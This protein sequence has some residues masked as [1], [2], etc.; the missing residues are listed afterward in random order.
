MSGYQKKK[1]PYNKKDQHETIKEERGNRDAL[2]TTTT[3]S[4]NEFIE[5]S[6]YDGVAKS[7]VSTTTYDDSYISGGCSTAVSSSYYD[8]CHGANSNQQE[9]YRYRNNNNNNDDGDES[10]FITPQDIYI[11]E[12]NR[13]NNSIK[14]NKCNNNNNKKAIDF[15]NGNFGYSIDWNQAFQRLLLL[16]EDDLEKKYV[17][18]KHLSSLSKD[19]LHTAI[20]YGKIIIEEA[21]IDEK[22]KT[23]KSVNDIGGVAGGKKLCYNG[24]LF[25]FA[26]DRFKIYGSDEFSMKSGGHELKSVMRYYGCDG[27]HVPLMALL[28][29]RGFRLVAMSILPITKDTIIYGSQDA[30]VTVHDSRPEF[31]EYM[32][33]AAAKLNIKGHIAGITNESKAFLYGPTDIEGH[34]G[35]DGLFYLLDFARVFPPTIDKRVDE[36]FLYRLFRP[37]FLQTYHIPLSSDAASPFSKSDLPSMES[38]MR[39]VKDATDYLINICIPKL[40]EWMQTRTTTIDW[41]SQLTEIIHREGV[42]IRYLGYIR[43]YITEPQLKRILL[44]EIVARVLKNIMREELREKMKLLKSLEADSYIQVVMDFFNIV[45]GEPKKLHERLWLSILKNEILL[46]FDNSLSIE[47][48]EENFDIRNSIDIYYV[49]VRIQ[50]MTGIKLAEVSMRELKKDYKTFRVVLPDIIS[51]DVRVKHMNIISLAEGNALSLQCMKGDGRGSERLFKLA[52]NKFEEA[53]RSTPDNKDILNEYAGVLKEMALTVGRDDAITYLEKSY[54]NFLLANNHQSLLQLGEH[55]NTLLEANHQ[56]L[57]ELR[58]P[59]TKVVEKC[60]TSVAFWGSETRNH[61]LHSS[62]DIINRRMQSLPTISSLEK[63]IAQLKLAALIMRCAKENQSIELLE[64]SGKFYKDAFKLILGDSALWSQLPI[65]EPI[66]SK[67][68]IQIALWA[69]LFLGDSAKTQF[70][71]LLSSPYGINFSKVFGRNLL[72]S[73]FLI[74]LSKIYNRQ[75][76]HFSLAKSLINFECSLSPVLKNLG[77]TLS[78]LDLSNCTQLYDKDMQSIYSH[79]TRLKSINISKTGVETQGIINLLLNCKNLVRLKA[80]RCRIENS[81]FVSAIS[82]RQFK[83]IKCIDFSATGI[84]MIG[85]IANAM[86]SLCHVNFS[87]CVSIHNQDFTYFAQNSAG[88]L[89]KANFSSCYGFTDDALVS[90][91]EQNPRTIKSLVVNNCKLSYMSV[92]NILKFN[93]KIE[94][95]LPIQNLDLANC[96]IKLITSSHH[97]SQFS[98]SSLSSLVSIDLSN[99]GVGQEVLINCLVE[100]HNIEKILFNNN[101][102]SPVKSSSSSLSIP[103]SPS[104]SSSSLSSSSTII[105]SH[106]LKQLER[107]PKQLKLHTLEVATCSLP[108]TFLMEI[109]RRSPMLTR[110]NVSRCDIDA[111]F[112]KCLATHANN[113]TELLLEYCKSVNDSIIE[114]FIPYC[115]KITNLALSGCHLITGQTI[116]SISNHLHQ[117]RTLSLKKCQLIHDLTPI[118]KCI[119]VKFIDL[120]NSENILDASIISLVSLPRLK[121]LNLYGCRRVTDESIGKI[122]EINGPISLKTLILGL[123]KTSNPAIDLLRSQ[124]PELNILT[125]SSLTSNSSSGNLISQ[126]SGSSSSSGYLSSSNNSELSL[127]SN[128]NSSI[129]TSSSTNST[130]SNLSSSTSS[131]SSSNNLIVTPSTLKSL[132]ADLKNIKMNPLPLVSAEP[133]EGDL[134]TWHANIIAPDES[135]YEGGI[136]H[137]ELKFPPTYPINPPSG[138]LLTP[139]PHPHIHDKGRICLDI[140]SDFQ[141]YFQGNDSINGPKST[142][143]SSAYSVQ[144]ILLQIQTFLITLDSEDDPSALPIQEYLSKIPQAIHISRTF[145]CPSCSHCAENPW[146]PITSN[147]TTSSTKSNSNNTNSLSSSS[148]SILIVNNSTTSSSSS[149]P[150]PLSSSPSLSSNPLNSNITIPKLQFNNKPMIQQSSSSNQKIE[151][152]YIKSIESELICFHTRVSY[153]ED[154]LGIGISSTTKKNKPRKIDEIKSTLD[155][156]SKTA[157][158]QGVRNSVL[159]EQF[160]HWLPLYFNPQHGENAWVYLEASLSDMFNSKKFYPEIACTFLCKAMN[161]MC[162]QIMNGTL[163]A[164][165]KLLEGYCSFHQLFLV[166]VKKYPDLLS[167]INQ[168]IYDFI[169]IPEKR[170]KTNTPALGEFL[171]LLT[172]SDYKWSEVSRAYLEENFDRNVFWVLK[173]HPELSETDPNPTVDSNRPKLVFDCTLVSIKLLLFHVYFLRNVARPAGS[174][175]EEIMLQ[176]NKLL[177]RPPP[178]IRDSLQTEV[179]QIQRISTWNEFFIKIDVTPPTDDALVEWLRRSV[180]NSLTKKYHNAKG[181]N[182]NIYISVPNHNSKLSD[183]IDY[184]LQL[185]SPPLDSIIDYNN[186]NSGSSIQRL[187]SPIQNSFS[188]LS[189]SD[190]EDDNVDFKNPP[191]PSPPSPLLS[192]RIQTKF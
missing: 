172:V 166:L 151:E 181:K 14:N 48:R 134:L 101:S 165:I 136:F 124:H 160:T 129:S 70:P 131:S 3:V 106:L 167:Q 155:L 140:L 73:D 67:N 31:N 114:L 163:H 24:I 115:N 158:N 64:K 102:D 118:Q 34:Y 12:R 44:T 93:Q 2:T 37:E 89:E 54:S 164:S 55:L 178:S 68:N 38:N 13:D 105:S 16:P 77:D 26:L 66:L 137:I 171:P 127:S 162:V 98:I 50:M 174:S 113:I 116:Q 109:I 85:T 5:S 19:F 182:N 91:I 11:S 111:P 30:G 6:C 81:T 176:Y 56:D 187:S 95:G 25:K 186:N 191:S 99:T 20:T 132:M 168:Q 39:E 51:M 41:Y 97:S 78:K 173:K 96:K 75:I 122:S 79:C 88:R 35:L 180:S 117:L 27:I 179:K 21:F 110:I 84:K 59:L 72:E 125:P 133:L 90:L 130:S 15:N 74:F 62:V 9:T 192:P 28:D 120:S 139:F 123:N 154:I 86:P 36:A 18:Y 112:F 7:T 153:K 148:S 8:Y 29:Y 170:N 135:P 61:L 121:H 69:Q 65:P 45:L 57:W 156:L 33:S 92:V 87:K 143:W 159:K 188:S 4:S 183:E 169:H 43:N 185:F 138:V 42:N 108:T 80:H 63:C 189:L 146:P 141:S 60:F 104:S 47:E 119:Y 1:S 184:N 22:Y 128:I 17:K 23:I 150:T 10:T 157:F 58:G 152:T 177:G 94:G 126:S 52:T 53:I 147:T 100:C 71:K 142:G 49:F 144:T 40:S 175:I 145:K 82:K 83:N 103:L 190:S 161:T 149:T 76:S 46:R 32:R 107:I